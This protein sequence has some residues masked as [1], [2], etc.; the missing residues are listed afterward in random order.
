MVEMDIQNF[1]GMRGI[2]RH[3]QFYICPTKIIYSGILLSRYL[4]ATRKNG[5]GNIPE[6][7]ALQN[8]I[9]KELLKI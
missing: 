4:V 3:Y 7:L 2:G 5:K 1:V 9:Y 6:M 8:G